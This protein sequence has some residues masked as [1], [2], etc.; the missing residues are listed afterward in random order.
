MSKHWRHAVVGT[1]VVGDW[2]VKMIPN[3]P[4]S[5]LV[6]VCDKDPAKTGKSLDKA[7]LKEIP[8]YQDLA[9]LLS[10]E[11]IDVLHVCTPSGDHMNPALAAIERG[12]HVIV[13]K[14]MEIQLDRI[15]RM[16]E[17]AEKKGVRLAAIFQNRW[18]EANAAIKK[19]ADEGRFGKFSWAASITPWHRNDQYYRDGGWRGTWKWDG[20][21][22]VMNQSVHA[23][24]LLQWIVGPV[25]QV[26]AY[27]GSRI[28]PEIEVEDTLSCAC[29]FKNGAFG[30][31]VGT[32]AVWPGG[33]VRI[34][35]GGEKGHAVSEYALRAYRFKDERP[36]DKEI[37][38]RL[39]AIKKTSIIAGAGSNTDV[40]IDNHYKNVTAILDAWERGEDAPTNGREARKAVAIILAMYESAKKNGA[41]V[42][43]K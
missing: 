7:N 12:I 34:E 2:H 22:A 41:P 39:G 4:H 9:D 23:I 26:S 16:C 28:H 13:E 40:P 37:L 18:N 3:L 5:T 42:E 29:Q 31:I 43:V 20:G 15:D 25:A 6:A 21:G 17:A 11:K 1:G 36:E 35:V 27:A 14:P 38:E 33:P 19:A 8:Q 30:T 32:T 10:K 24:D